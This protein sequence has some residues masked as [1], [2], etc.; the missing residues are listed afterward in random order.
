[1]NILNQ[2]EIEMVS[3][4]LRE[5]ETTVIAGKTYKCVNGQ[6]TLVDIE[7]QKDTMEQLVD[8]TRLDQAESQDSSNSYSFG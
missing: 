6:L 1:M 5:G 2:H 7:V 3:G 4:C 8:D